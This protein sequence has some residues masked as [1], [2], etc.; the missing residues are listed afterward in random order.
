ML[1]KIIV[2]F[3]S[4]LNHVKNLIV[5]TYNFYKT[6]TSKPTPLKKKNHAEIRTPLFYF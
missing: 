6:F 2:T 1:I 5:A 4:V 3:L